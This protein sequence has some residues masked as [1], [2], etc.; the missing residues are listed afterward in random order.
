M[1]CHLRCITLDREACA[2]ALGLTSEDLLGTLPTQ[3]VSAGNSF[4]Y[5]PLRDAATVDRA[6]LDE[7][8]LAALAPK[9]VATGIFFFAPHTGNTFYSR[10]LA[11]LSGVPEDPATGSA[12]GPL[13]AYLFE[14]GLIARRDGER[15]VNEQGVRMKRRSLIHGIVRAAPDGT[16]LAV[17][18]GG[19]AVKTS[20]ATMTLPAT[21]TPAATSRS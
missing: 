12:T 18:V 3:I 21:M 20:D 11:P 4:L 13:G 19:S 5:V 15:F 10:M 6:S 1:S 16:L 2:R 9:G 17:D 7:R 14:H 8:A